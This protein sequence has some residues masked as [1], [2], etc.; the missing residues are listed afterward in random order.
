MASCVPCRL[1]NRF[2]DQQFHIRCQ[3]LDLLHKKVL[4]FVKSVTFDPL[5]QWVYD[6]P[7][8]FSSICLLFAQTKEIKSNM[9]MIGTTTLKNFQVLCGGIN[10]YSFPTIGVY[11]PVM[12]GNSGSFT[13]SFLSQQPILQGQGAI[14]GLLPVVE[15]VYSNNKYIQKLQ[16]NLRVCPWTYGTHCEMEKFKTSCIT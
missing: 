9:N 14:L 2:P 4:Y 11:Y 16:N 15:N 6:N 3:E 5:P 10:L 1:I 13:W 12:R 7:Q 8:P